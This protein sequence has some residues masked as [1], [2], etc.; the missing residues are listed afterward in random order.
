MDTKGVLTATLLQLTQEDDFPFCLLHRDVIVLDALEVLLHLVELVVVRGEEC[1]CLRL[2]MLM[3]VFHN[4]PGNRNAVIGRGSSSQLVKQYQR[5]WCHII[6][7]VRRLCH[8]YHKCRFTQRNIITGPYPREYLVH[9]TD[10]SALCRHKRTY[11]GQQ[12]Y[13]GCLTQQRRFTCHIRTCNH[14]N[15]LTLLV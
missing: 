9:Q 3:Q 12:Y 13:Q 2:R 4:S 1:T 6:Q 7:N 14:N 8:L 15:L 5:T 11:L 10:S